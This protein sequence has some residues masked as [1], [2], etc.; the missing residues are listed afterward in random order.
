VTSAA[1]DFRART[2]ARVLDMTVSARIALAL[3]L[4]DD[5]LAIF[6]RSS[7]LEPTE[8]RRRLR[9][10]RGRGRTPSA[11]AGPPLP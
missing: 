3:A 8:A 7:G 1:D 9:A 10:Q 6:V 11:C 5:D 2:I 4:G